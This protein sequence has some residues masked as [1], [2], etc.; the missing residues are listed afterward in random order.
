MTLASALPA[1]FAVRVV[2]TRLFMIQLLPVTTKVNLGP[3]ARLR[4]GILP[5]PGILKLATT[6]GLQ[7]YC[8]DRGVLK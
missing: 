1:G 7:A 2:R 8:N 6:A 3:F 4:L 5:R